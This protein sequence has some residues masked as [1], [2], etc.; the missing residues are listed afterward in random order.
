[1]AALL[2]AP[3]APPSYEPTIET[4]YLPAP[5]VAAEL[6]TTAVAAGDGQ[7]AEQAAAEALARRSRGVSGTVLTSWRGV[8]EPGAF[9]LNAALPQRKRLLGE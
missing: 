8:V 5:T 3:K 6:V 2:A 4:V 7:T 9:E 1:M